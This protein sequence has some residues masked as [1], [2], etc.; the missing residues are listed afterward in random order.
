M[1]CTVDKAPHDVPLVL[2]EIKDEIL[3]ER[4][5]RLGVYPGDILMRLDEDV[6]LGTARVRGPLGE[7]VLPGGMASKVIVHHD[8]GHK[9]PIIEMHPGE[10]GHVEG[11]MCGC[12][13]ADSLAIMGIR[14]NDP[15]KMVR[16]VP[17]MIYHALIGKK[18]VLLT[19]GVATKIWGRM[20][21]LD[22]QFALA[23][24]G[25]AFLVLAL[26]DG[27]RAESVSRNLAIVPG[28]VIVLK[29]VTSA[30]SVGHAGRD[31]IVLS[32]ESGMAILP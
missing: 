13:L 31:Q 26:L 22:M 3:S 32:M 27:R 18:E 8:D 10:K 4:L 24:K 20:D 30:Y 17:P 7:M 25:K 29:E 15:V 5:F 2:S 12:K 16:R 14:E 28:Q 6:I 11:L 23:G 19:E 9:T 21:G 1:L